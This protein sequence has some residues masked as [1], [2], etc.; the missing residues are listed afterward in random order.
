MPLGGPT[1]KRRRDVKLTV[2]TARRS[3]PT[4]AKAK[5]AA[6]VLRRLEGEYG[7]RE[8]TPRGRPLD[9]FVSVILS[10]NTSWINAREGFRRL[11]RDLPTWERAL[12][13]PVE[14]VQRS[15]AVC[16]LGRMRA[17]RLQALLRRIK[18][19]RG[20]LTLAFVGRMEVDEAAAY[21][22]SFHG[23]G[24]KTVACTLLF[25]FGMPIFP[26]DNGI[27]R[28]IRRLGLVRAKAKDVEASGIVERAT[29]PL[30]RYPLHVLTYRH[31]KDFCRPK[32]PHCDD[33]PLLDLCPTGR[34][35]V[36]HAPPPEPPPRPKRL[37]RSISAGLLRDGDAA[38]R[39]GL[40]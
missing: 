30:M 14:E 28:V 37:S 4:P 21:L 39:R 5:L 27:L 22:S 25:A 18:A 29:T 32:N 40:R 35:R 19:E 38:E 3:R 11:K 2:T 15:I 31:A 23:V 9:V 12:A 26:V 8:W 7:R 13:A 1:S 6:S 10:Q 17:G 36:K 24:P 33:C 20:R 34:R 16:G